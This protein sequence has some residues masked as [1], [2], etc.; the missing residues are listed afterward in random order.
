MGRVEDAIG[1]LQRVNKLHLATIET[2]AH[3]V[4]AK[5]QVTHGH[6]RRVQNLTTQVASALGVT[7]ELQ[8]RAIEASALLHDMG[9]LAIPEHILNK[10]GK[11]T[12][13]EFE[14]MKLHARNRSG[15][16][17]FN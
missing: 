10:P 11:L 5:D 14:K 2:L 13:A 4:D 6:I 16:T 15:N 7:D 9:K 3:A 8:L 1:H 12:V 17:V